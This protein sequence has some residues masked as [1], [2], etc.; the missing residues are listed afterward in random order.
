MM[1]SLQ[2]LQILKNAHRQPKLFYLTVMFL[3]LQV[4]ACSGLDNVNVT[5]ALQE[6]KSESAPP[7]KNS[8]STTDHRLIERAD[9]T[10]TGTP[11]PVFMVSTTSHLSS[12][13]SEPTY[14]HGFSSI[15]LP[16]DAWETIVSC[17]PDAGLFNLMSTSRGVKSLLNS[18]DVL[19]QFA[20]QR[21]IDILAT[22]MW[23]ANSKYCFINTTSLAFQISTRL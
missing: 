12:S 3:S 15:R 2:P 4:S 7:P 20:Q 9:N 6:A 17:L 13:S 5:P 23:V 11:N 14:K 19:A 18:H 21:S 10:P 16:N 1:S 22:H 8:S